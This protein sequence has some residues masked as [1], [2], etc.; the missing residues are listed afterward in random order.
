MKCVVLL[1]DLWGWV[2]LARTV[3]VN[4]GG[5]NV[6]S[7]S[8]A[9]DRIGVSHEVS[10]SPSAIQRADRVI[11]PGVGAFDTVARRLSEMQVLDTVKTF[12]RPL[13]GIC[14]GM[15]IL[16]RGSSEGNLPG[17]GIIDSTIDR[18]P[19]SSGVTVPHMGWNQLVTIGD[20]EES[21][22]SQF[23]KEWFYFTHSYAAPISSN[24]LATVK[25][26]IDFTSIC[27]SS[28]FL[29]VQFHPEKSGD[30]GLDFLSGFVKQ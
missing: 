17:L 6:G 24:T 16:Y 26:G 12:N 14:V 9:L 11:L 23:Q 5:A 4:S 18:I 25:H 1:I 15:Q 21:F 20:S 28:N 13:L 2:K 10:I 7:V 19:E 8:F 29:G 22:V 30:L 27:S 3:I